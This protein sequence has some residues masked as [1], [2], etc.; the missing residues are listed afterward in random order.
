MTK[1]NKFELDSDL[2]EPIALTPEQLAQVSGTDAA[3]GVAGGTVSVTHIIIGLIFRPT[4]PM[5]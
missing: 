5:V 3:A 4:A 2:P 1:Q